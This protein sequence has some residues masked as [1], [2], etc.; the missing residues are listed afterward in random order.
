[1]LHAAWSWTLGAGRRAKLASLV[2]CED[3]A[4]GHDARIIFGA[5]LTVQQL[6]IQPTTV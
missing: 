3:H 2:L 6:E 1:M 5:A 4:V